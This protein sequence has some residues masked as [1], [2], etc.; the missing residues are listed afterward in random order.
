[1]NEYYVSEFMILSVLGVLG[2]LWLQVSFLLVDMMVHSFSSG[3][4]PSVAIRS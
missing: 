1:M 2:L 4:L 3:E